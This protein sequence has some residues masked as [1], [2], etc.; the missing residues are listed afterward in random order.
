MTSALKTGAAIA[1]ALAFLAT[2]S[3]AEEALTVQSGKVTMPM[4]GVEIDIPARPGTEFS[5]YGSWGLY[6]DENNI[7]DARDVVEEFPVDGDDPSAG[8]WFYIEFLGEGGC[9]AS[10]GN[11]PFENVWMSEETL[12]GNT[13]LVRGGNYQLDSV[14]PG[15]ISCRT[16]PGGESVVMYRFLPQ[17]PL[18]TTKAEILA[19]LRASAPGAA[20]DRAI[21]EGAVV[22]VKPMHLGHVFNSGESPAA[23]PMALAASGLTVNLPDDGYFWTAT[24]YNNVDLIS[25][26]VPVYPEMH[27]ETAKISGWTCQQVFASADMV[28]DPVPVPPGL[29]ASWTAESRVRTDGYMET[30]LCHPLQGGTLIV[31]LYT[32][33]DTASLSEAAP[34]L[35]ALMEA[36]K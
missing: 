26:E 7:L 4:T 8:S 5:V 28:G 15:S 16:Y 21:A 1:A 2:P 13:W 18:T 20:F 10:I 36:A 35:G 3:L 6:P 30:A 27:L 14:M 22:A 17:K 9:M 32:S 33:K 19:E 12:W 34:L 29:P 23:R 11:V 24:V 31:S 25:R